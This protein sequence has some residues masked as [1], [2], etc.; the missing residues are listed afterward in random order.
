MSAMLALSCGQHA[1][2]VLDLHRQPHGVGR[3]VAACVPFDVDAPLG[4][5]QQV[6]DVGAVRRV[7]RHALAAGDVADDPLAADRVAAAR[8]DHHQVV[9][10]AHGDAVGGAAPAS[11]RFT[12]DTTGWSGAFSFS[13]PAGTSA[14]ST[15]RAAIL[16]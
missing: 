15:W 6:D 9:G 13:W 10:A 4:V 12:A 1:L 3:G 8:A 7:H 11:S 2:A 14:S 5:V 16:P